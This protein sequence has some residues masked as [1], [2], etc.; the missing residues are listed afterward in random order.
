MRTLHVTAAAS[1]KRFDVALVGGAD[2]LTQAVAARSGVA[3]FYLTAQRSPDSMLVP[4]TA[5]LPDGS[6]LTL[7]A[8][9]EPSE[10]APAARARAA[11]PAAPALTR[12]VTT[13]SA[14]ISTAELQRQGAYDKVLTGLE[15]LNRLSTDLANERTLLAWI[16]TCLAAIRTVFTYL[17]I[18]AATDAWRAS[19]LATEVAMA[20][21]VVATAVTGAWRFYKIKAVISLK[22]PPAN[23]GRY[24]LRPLIALVVATTVTTAF[25]IY[26]QQWE[27]V[28]H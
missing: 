12:A 21:L 4:L 22:V 10:P 5:E 25:G 11:A 2:A 9:S 20:T 7:H 3:K 27:K 8:V 17:A 16:R 1:G 26:T 18:T 6:Q 14:L 24:S 19:V 28:S 15:R 23:F 13:S